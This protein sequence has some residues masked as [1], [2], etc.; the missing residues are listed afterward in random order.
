MQGHCHSL[1]QSA[2]P[3]LSQLL[4]HVSRKRKIL[5]YNVVDLCEGGE[6]TFS[7]QPFA[8]VPAQAMKCLLAGSVGFVRHTPK[9]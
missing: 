9:L 4:V 2:V 3:M 6:A 7:R 8:A 1:D 5:L